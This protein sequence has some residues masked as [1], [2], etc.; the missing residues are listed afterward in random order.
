M[1]PNA[2]QE[3]RGFDLNAQ[4]AAG[5]LTAASRRRP[6]LLTR[7]GGD[8]DVHDGWE[9]RGGGGLDRPSLMGVKE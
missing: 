7:F 2:G 1:R 6:V 5:R 4:S 3:L 8:I 9:C